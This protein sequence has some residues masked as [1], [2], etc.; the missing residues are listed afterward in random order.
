MSFFGSPNWN[1]VFVFMSV[2]WAAIIM[3]IYARLRTFEN[4]NMSFENENMRFENENRRSENEN[5]RF[6]NENRSFDNENRSF[7][8]MRFA[9]NIVSYTRLIVC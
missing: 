2:L 1:F 6:E 9:N 7:E 5:M 3:K 8:N 4:E